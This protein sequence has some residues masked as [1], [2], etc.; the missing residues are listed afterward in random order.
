MTNSFNSLRYYF[1]TS[2]N[3]Q[4]WVEVENRLA[5]LRGELVLKEHSQ[6]EQ[7]AIN[8][9]K[10]YYRS[11]NKDNISIKS[12]LAEHGL[13]SLDSLELCVQLED[14]LGYII[15]AETMPKVTKVKHIVNL[16]KQFEAYKQEF[17]MTAQERAHK[18]EENWDDWMPK[19]EKLKQKLYGFVKKNKH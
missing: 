9:V 7:Y 2:S 4:P 1:S 13:D 16:I 11:T 12:T 3:V 15:E 14:E 17:K 19:G 6:M 10:G 8:L 5:K 18:D